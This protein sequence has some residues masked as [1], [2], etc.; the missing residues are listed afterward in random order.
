VDGGD[1]PGE[2]ESVEDVAD[3]VEELPRRDHIA[4]G[5]PNQEVLAVRDRCRVPH[6]VSWCGYVTEINRGDS[7]VG[8]T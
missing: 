6:H 8:A 5:R 7:D 3:L 2:D 1:D 4:G